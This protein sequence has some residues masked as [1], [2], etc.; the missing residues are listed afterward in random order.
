MMIVASICLAIA[1]YFSFVSF[2]ITLFNAMRWWSNHQSFLAL[3]KDT[4]EEKD[5]LRYPHLKDF[6]NVTPPLIIASFTWG[7]FFWSI[8]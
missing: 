5:K 3:A 4:R 7:V 2:S 6:K 8:H 1:L